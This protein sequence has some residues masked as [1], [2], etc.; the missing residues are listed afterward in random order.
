MPEQT[1]AIEGH[2][3]HEG[4]PVKPSM[5]LERFRELVDLATDGDILYSEAWELISEIAR[6]RLEIESLTNELSNRPR[7]TMRHPLDMD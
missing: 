5:T 4:V 6:Q 2:E 3:L 1:Y 7:S